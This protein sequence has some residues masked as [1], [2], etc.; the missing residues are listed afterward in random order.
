MV[1]MV[2]VTWVMGQYSRSTPTARVS[3]VFIVLPMEVTEP[4]RWLDWCFPGVHYLEQH[5]RVAV[6]MAFLVMELYLKLTP[7]V[8][9][10]PTFTISL[11]TMKG[12]TKLTEI[13]RQLTC[14]Y[15]EMFC[16][17]PRKEAATLAMEMCSKLA[18]MAQALWFFTIFQT[19]QLEGIHRQ[20]WSCLET[21]YMEQQRLAVPQDTEQYLRSIPMARTL[22]IFMVLLMEAMEPS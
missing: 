20:V 10:S 3:R 13:I 14:Y 11:T 9:V 16:M 4:T 5:Q 2:A 21:L 1:A 18:L 17:G 12:I 7:T 22:P 19:R 6:K 15:L 8:R